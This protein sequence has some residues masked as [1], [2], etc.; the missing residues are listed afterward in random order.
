MVLAIFQVVSS[1]ESVRQ[2]EA[3]MRDHG[4]EG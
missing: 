3:S 4:I 1:A 2:S